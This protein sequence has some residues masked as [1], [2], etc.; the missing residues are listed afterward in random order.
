MHKYPIVWVVNVINFEK[1]NREQYDNNEPVT[2]RGV[3]SSES[4]SDSGGETGGS[5]EQSEGVSQVSQP[6][7]YGRSQ[8]SGIS[9]S[10]RQGNQE[11]NAEG[12]GLSDGSQAVADYQGESQAVSDTKD[13]QRRALGESAEQS[14]NGQQV[15]PAGT[16]IKPAKVTDIPSEWKNSNIQAAQAKRFNAAS[17]IP[18]EAFT[19]YTLS[20]ILPTPSKNVGD[21]IGANGRDVLIKRG[22]F[23][24]NDISH[25]GSAKNP[26]SPSDSRTI[27]DGALYDGDLVGKT[28]PAKRPDYWVVIKTDDLNRVVVLEVSNSK[29]YLEIVGW[30][31]RDGKALRNLYNQAEKEGRE[32]LEI[33]KR[34]NREDGP[35]LIQDPAESSAAD[36]SALPDTS[37]EDK[38]TDVQPKKQEN[39]NKKVSEH[40]DNVKQS[41]LEETA[42]KIAE[43]EQQVNTNPTEV[44][45]EAGNYKKGHVKVGS[46][47][48]TIENPQGSVRRGTDANGKQRETVRDATDV[49]S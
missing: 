20:A 14:G 30:E 26:L 19:D 38:G 44:Q 4:N 48:I 45:K 23:A 12:E 13:S 41:P 8:A 47:D 9:S 21:A 27:I 39:E 28:Q 25:G 6:D 49:C 42:N 2:G 1:L 7:E 22:I 10:I 3:D 16:N 33:E 17:T 24:K 31:Y 34:S 11:R 36:L 15:E 29:E 35:F 18:D 32:I 5:A 43:A 37:S 40:A 46:F